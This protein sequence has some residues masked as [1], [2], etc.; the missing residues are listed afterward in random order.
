VSG[1]PVSVVIPVWNCEAY[2][3]EA[4]ASVLAQRHPVE[5]LLVDDGSTDG[6]VEAALRAAPELTVVRR[7]NGNRR[8]A[9][10]RGSAVARRAAGVFG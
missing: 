5:I 1:T 8:R 10:L 3:G 9:E 4:V 7:A 6:S 2:V